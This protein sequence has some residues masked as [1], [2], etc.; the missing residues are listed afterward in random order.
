VSTPHNTTQP[1]PSTTPTSVP[2]GWVIALAT[3]VAVVLALSMLAGWFGTGDPLAGP[4][5]LLQHLWWAAL[6]GTLWLLWARP[7]VRCARKSRRCG[8]ASPLAPAFALLGAI[9][10]IAALGYAGL[11]GTLVPGIGWLTL[12]CLGLLLIGAMRGRRDGLGQ[13]LVRLAHA[14]GVDWRLWSLL[15]VLALPSAALLMTAAVCPPGSLWASEAQGYDVLSYHLPLPSAWQQG[16]RASVVEHNAYSALPLYAEVA[17]ATAAAGFARLISAFDP[18]SIMLASGWHAALTLIAACTIARGAGLM[19]RRATPR[20]D[21]WIA[22]TIGGCFVL[23]VPWT[24]VT[25]SL[26]YNEHL[27]TLGFAVAL[28]LVIGVREL[29]RD[30]VPAQLPL[31]RRPRAHAAAIG[32]GIGFALG[33]ASGAK[34]SSFFLTVPPVVIAAFVLHAPKRAIVMLAW[35]GFGG[36]IALLPWLLRNWIEL[37]NPVFPYATGLLGTAH[38]TDEQVARWMAA[39]GPE[40]SLADRAAMLLGQ[41]GLGHRQ[42]G[43]FAPAIVGLGTA[44]VLRP[45]K[46]P[47]AAALLLGL[48]AQAAAWVLIGHQQSR[49]LLPMIV[50]GGLLVALACLPDAGGRAPRNAHAFAVAAALLLSAQSWHVYLGQNSPDGSFPANPAHGLVLGVDGLTG[51]PYFERFDA[52]SG[53][54]LAETYQL[55]GPVIALNHGLAHR[56][57]AAARAQPAPRTPHLLLVGDATPLYYLEGPGLRVSWATTW[58]AHPLVDALNATGTIGDAL[59]RLAEQGITHILINTRELS[60]LAGSG[61]LDPALTPDPIRSIL[62]GPDAVHRWF[63]PT[64]SWFDGSVVLLEPGPAHPAHPLSIL[65]AEEQA[66]PDAPVAPSGSSARSAS[67]NPKAGARSRRVLQR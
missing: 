51:R 45:S 15:A 58:D 63:V 30:A 17:F 2:A 5:H 12:T 49:F 26:A 35:A 62:F 11:I 25:G 56:Y 38:W 37:G 10:A 31:H 67:E 4:T 66:L 52:L 28:L 33:V 50:P 1:E 55:T 40:G 14:R 16:G 53:T 46:R 54:A 13:S 61:Y 39:H 3:P 47:L 21:A 29:D 44:A 22:G 59:Q 65:G 18:R 36:L 32:L 20:R 23:A 42:W 7:V 19:R 43:V 57:G 64:I 48:L 6:G 9:W 60:R 41:R 27:V 24:I 8:A 34:P